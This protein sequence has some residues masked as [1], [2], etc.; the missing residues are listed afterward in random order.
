ML[1]KDLGVYSISTSIHLRKPT[2][3]RNFFTQSFELLVSDKINT[4][5]AL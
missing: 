4:Y 1:K 2:I 5:Y 3:H